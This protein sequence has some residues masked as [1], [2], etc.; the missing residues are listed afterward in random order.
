[1]LLVFDL[2]LLLI[3][4]DKSNKN[5]KKTSSSRNDRNENDTIAYKDKSDIEHMKPKK[6]EIKNISIT[7][8]EETKAK[9]PFNS[10]ELEKIGQTNENVEVM[11]VSSK[12]EN[13][14]QPKIV[15]IINNKNNPVKLRNIL[16]HPID[17]TPALK[18]KTPSSKTSSFSS[19]LSEQSKISDSIIIMK[20]TPDD[21]IKW[22]EYQNHGIPPSFRVHDKPL[23]KNGQSNNDRQSP[24]IYS[25]K[26]N[27]NI[28][29][30][31]PAN[32]QISNRSEKRK[33]SRLEK[34]NQSDQ[35]NLIKNKIYK[36]DDLFEKPKEKVIDE[37]S[38]NESKIKSKNEKSTKSQKELIFVP[39]NTND[40]L[41]PTIRGTPAEFI[42]LMKEWPQD[43]TKIRGHSSI[44]MTTNTIKSAKNRPGDLKR[45][46]AIAPVV[47]SS[48]EIE[49]K[50]SKLNICKIEIRSIRNEEILTLTVKLH[51][52]TLILNN[53]FYLTT[54]LFYTAN[55]LHNTNRNY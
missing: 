26:T 6:E 51:E 27:G 23:Y 17:K 16:P 22:E 45:I 29:M 9:Q 4:L 54:A 47:K 15:K 2:N 35:A 19:T 52:T 48:V 43:Y 8:K 14:S 55:K 34:Y 20:K 1:M 11:I 33:E 41:K 40:L 21:M 49:K 37:N 7:I 10:I 42:K 32:D 13:P 3:A 50:S 36:K 38:E 31:K 25:K 44:Q 28:E 53:C 24:N 46:N 18:P 12:K 5:E 30:R 39:P